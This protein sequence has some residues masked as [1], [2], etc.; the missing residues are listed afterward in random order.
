MRPLTTSQM[1]AFI[2][3]KTL[4]D[5]LGESPTRTE[6]AERLGCSRSWVQAATDAL[7]VKGLLLRGDRATP[8]NLRLP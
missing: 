2:A 1:V 8:R 4:V 5:E 6:L 7:V 3:F